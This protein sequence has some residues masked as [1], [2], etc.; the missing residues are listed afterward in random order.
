MHHRLTIDGSKNIYNL[1]R[2][3]AREK[4]YATKPSFHTFHS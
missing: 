2:N 3:G 4:I 1:D